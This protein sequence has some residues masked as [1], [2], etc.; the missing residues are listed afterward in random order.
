MAYS[1]NKIKVDQISSDEDNST[2]KMASHELSKTMNPDAEPK[3]LL[4]PIDSK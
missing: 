1:D 2:H 3:F 4:P